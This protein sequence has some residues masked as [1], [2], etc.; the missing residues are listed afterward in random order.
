[1][2][3]AISNWSDFTPTFVSKTNAGGTKK[4]IQRLNIADPGEHKVRLVGKPIYYYRYWV[5]GKAAICEDP[6][7][8]PV[9]QKYGID[10]TLRYA[11]N[12]LDRNDGD[13]LKIM[14]F[15]QTVYDQIKTLCTKRSVSN[16]GDEF[17][18]DFDIIVTGSKPKIKT[19]ILLGD[20]TPF[21][22]SQKEY[23]KANI[24]E[25]KKIYKPVPSNEIE[26]RLFPTKS[27]TETKKVSKDDD[28]GF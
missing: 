23:I 17:G 28:L 24:F 20:K 1:M 5:G 25:L 3:E 7:T 19:Q 14:E 16:P 12:V 6:S 2:A 10:P 22:D 18:P 26:E 8:C 9:R 21:T 4:D 27:N 13:K 11:V 15:S